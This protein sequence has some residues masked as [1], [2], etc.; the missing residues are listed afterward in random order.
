MAFRVLFVGGS[1][2]ISLPCVVSAVAAGHDV[3]VLNRGRSA[4]S[5]PSSVTRKTGDMT[6]V[7]SYREA[8]DGAYDVVC[9][10]LVFEPQQA[11]RDIALFAGKTG[12]YIF[13]SSASAYRKPVTD[14]P[15]TE[16]VPLDNPHWHYSRQ[17][18]AC[19]KML[20]EQDRLPVTIVRPSH[21]IRTKFPTALGESETAVSRMLR[22]L[23][24]IVPGD[25]N[26]LWT[27]TRAEDFAP[28]FVGLFGRVETLGEAYHLTSDHA[29]PWDAIYAAIGR[30]VGAVPDLVHVP[31]DNLVRFH[32][33][34]EGY[35]KGDKAYSVLFDNAKIK[36][37]VGD[38]TCE[39]DLDTLMQG[40][41][42]HWLA[43]GG[44]DTARPSGNLDP[45]FD[46]IIALQ[47]RV[48]P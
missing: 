22:D 7:R 39:R 3:T 5:L 13:I 38:F 28:P 35:L 2:Q 8:A 41:L 6:D 12:Q 4:V 31:T 20:L 32:P 43:R 16:A 14:C 11:A 26:A 30:A 18:A 45:L 25:G 44:A 36:S 17:K 37:V 10:F 48:Q 9:Q 46:R 1:G 42:E 34:W 29:Y 19:E 40:P 24:V 23:P 21:T 15:I 33:D 47:S 27:L